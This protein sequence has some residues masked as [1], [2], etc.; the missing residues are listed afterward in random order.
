[1]K[2]YIILNKNNNERANN[3]NNLIQSHK[4]E[5]DFDLKIFD[6]IM[7]K[8]YPIK[9]SWGTLGM[10][11]CWLS[12]QQIWQELIRN[13]EQDPVLIIEDDFKIGPIGFRAVMNT[14]LKEV[15]EDWDFIMLGYFAENSK[16]PISNSLCIASEFSGTHFYLINPKN[17]K[18]KIHLFDKM[19]TQIDWKIK[20][21]MNMGELNVYLTNTNLSSQSGFITTVQR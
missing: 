2:A 17:L 15:D 18:K 19:T 7:G 1:M 16:L 21:L 12:H 10:I 5:K 3:V 4:L 14:A 20:E 9:P 8:N 6:A 11:G 13:N